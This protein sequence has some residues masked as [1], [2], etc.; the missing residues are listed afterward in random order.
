MRVYEAICF[1]VGITIS[2]L[3]A[4][5]ISGALIKSKDSAFFLMIHYFVEELAL[6]FIRRFPFCVLA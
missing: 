6:I 3:I 5:L 1:T 2:S 4:F